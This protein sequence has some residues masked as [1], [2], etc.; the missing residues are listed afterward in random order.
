MTDSIVTKKNKLGVNVERSFFEE[1]SK[2]Y[3]ERRNKS[4]LKKVKQIWKELID[5]YIQ[6]SYIDY[7][8]IG[9]GTGESFEL[10]SSHFK[11]SYGMDIA[12]GMVRKAYSKQKIKK[13]LFV[14][15]AC[16]LPLR[17][18]SFDFVICQD[19]LEHV[20]YQEQLLLEV[21]RILR[22][23]GIG[24]IA[25]PNP[26]WEPLLYLAE[27]MSMKNQEGKHKF[28][29]LPKMAKKVLDSKCTIV[30]TSSFMM[31]PIESRIDSIIEPLKNSFLSGCGVEL[32]CVIKK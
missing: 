11:N 26:L 2:V 23:Q 22:S 12:E 5:Q 16:N 27:K 14:G 1:W 19:V 10:N 6:P 32:M 25:T 20:P 17:S 3:D 8:E 9:L 13:H 30:S 4:Y 24:I 18:N 29:N 21:Y 7:L 15:D 28:V 31:L